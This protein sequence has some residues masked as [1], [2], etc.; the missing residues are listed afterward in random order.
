MDSQ[1]SLF[2]EKNPFSD[3]FPENGKILLTGGG[4][5]LVERLGVEAIKSVVYSVM[6]G[7]NLRTQTE[8]LSRR[9][10]AQVS[11]ALIVMFAKGQIQIEDFNEKISG[12]AF[13]QLKTARKADNSAVWPAQWSLGLTGKSVQNVLRSSSEA[14]SGYITEFERAIKDAAQHCLEQYGQYNM[15]LGYV[16]DGNGQTVELDWEGITRLTTLI[17]AQTLAIRG[18]D[19][20]MY[21]KLFEKLILG[22]MLSILG[23]KR[24]DPRTNTNTEKVFWLSDSTA[25]RESDA[26][27]LVTAGKVARFDIGFIGP[28]NPEISKDKLSRFEA[29]ITLTSGKSNSVTFII[30]DKLPQ[31][32]KTIDAATRIGS[33]IIQ[34]SMQ[35]WPR[36][37]AIKMGNRFNFTHPLQTMPDNEIADYVRGMLDPIA[38]QE[39]LNEVSIAD[40]EEE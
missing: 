7:E 27:A 17:G 36:E 32:S 24:V 30:I 34:M 12:L 39:F 8:F 15:S 29:E 31:T 4:K 6:L 13:K 1:S 20:S 3:L 25:S 26:T 33:E 21:G 37:L 16:E 2:P 18:S 9:R 5:Q 11:G 19:K 38:I 35:Y 22:S 14:Y 10:I 40:L 28:G 23:F